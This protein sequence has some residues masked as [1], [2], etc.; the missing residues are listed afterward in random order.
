MMAYYKLAETDPSL[1]QKTIEVDTTIP[2]NQNIEPS[3]TLEPKKSY[4]IDELIRRMIVYSDNE[5]YEILQKNIDNKL[6]VQ[7]YTDLGIDISKGY[8]D[9][10]GNILTVKDYASFFRILYN[11]SYL[12]KASS[13][14]ALDLLTKVDYKDGLIKGIN[15]PKVTIAHKFGERQ[16]TETGEK[17]LHDCG[18]VYLPQKPFLIC[19]MTRGSDFNK[20]SSAI[21]QISSMIYLNINK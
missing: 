5:A 18:I 16:F 1:L 21:N 14:K 9:P 10:T 4:T 19:V 15:D 11:A 8:S 6:I 3:I 12:D 17:Q 20:L 2:D 13:Q 7:A